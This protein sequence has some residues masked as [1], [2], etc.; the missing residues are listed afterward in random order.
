M[1]STSA[2]AP[3]TSF[4]SDP[5][6][7]IEHAGIQPGM[8]I[9][10]FGSGSGR[11]AMETAKALVATGKVYA[12]DSI[13][14]LATRTAAL[15]REERMSNIDVIVGDVTTPR[16]SLLADSSLD[17]V[18]MSNLLFQLTTSE[19]KKTA[20]TEAKRV[21]QPGGRVLVVDW[22]DSFGGIGP[23]AQYV[24]SKTAAQVLFEKNGFAAE[25]E[26]DAG[27]HHYGYIFK[28]L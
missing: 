24:V 21:L 15:A 1:S 27:S 6:I 11:Y 18:I 5:H 28:K 10:D 25:R 20:L 26:L 19:D 14:E 3:V 9:A 16:G 23:A 17:M 8:V 13:P 4:F 12:I 7:V 22:Q 2:P